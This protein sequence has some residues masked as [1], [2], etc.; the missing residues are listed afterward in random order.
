M[1]ASYPSR[2]L[3]HSFFLVLFI[4]YLYSMFLILIEGYSGVVVLQ[5]FWSYVLCIVYNRSISCSSF[6]VL[7]EWVFY[8][9]CFCLRCSVPYRLLIVFLSQVA[10]FWMLYHAGCMWTN[11]NLCLTGTAELHILPPPVGDFGISQDQLSTIT[12]DHNHNALE[13]IGGVSLPQ[14]FL[15]DFMYCFTVLILHSFSCYIYA[16]GKRSCRCLKN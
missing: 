7:V 8:D 3:R 11:W 14:V 10:W 5:Q 16:P 13:E 4:F 12:R 15:I 1:R 2:N 9:F 6:G